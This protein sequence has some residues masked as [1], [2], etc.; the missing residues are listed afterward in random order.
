MK[1]RVGVADGDPTEPHA[2]AAN[3]SA[4]L[5]VGATSLGLARSSSKV[6]VADSGAVASGVSPTESVVA[7]ASVDVTEDPPS[8]ASASAEGL[9]APPPQL[10]ARSARTVNNAIERR[11]DFF[12]NPTERNADAILM[13][14]TMA[15]VETNTVEPLY[16]RLL[17][18]R[19]MTQS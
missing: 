6:V 15:P 17:E 11:P 12:L 8:V 4:S 2:M 10:A 1:V 18:Q 13:Q 14:A 19:R 9:S 3:S 7:T 16:D 5:V